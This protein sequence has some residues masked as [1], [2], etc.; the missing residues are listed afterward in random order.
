[1]QVA[2][3]SPLHRCVIV[4]QGSISRLVSSTRWQK[5]QQSADI[6]SSPLNK[7]P[8][9]TQRVERITARS[10]MKYSA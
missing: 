8:P 3:M 5:T 10:G 7:G 2:Q 6:L 9:H 4:L 1:L